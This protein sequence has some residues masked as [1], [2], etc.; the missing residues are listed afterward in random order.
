MYA[1]AN[2]DTQLDQRTRVYLLFTLYTP[3]RPAFLSTASST[4]KIDEEHPEENNDQE[5]RYWRDD[6]G[7][8]KNK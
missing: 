7:L 6:D 8:I 3:L 2:N 4:K 1:G 5:S